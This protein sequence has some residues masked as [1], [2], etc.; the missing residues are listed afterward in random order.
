VQDLG[1]SL[2]VT[3]LV[4]LRLVPMIAFSPPFT[5]VRVPALVRVMLVLAL[6]AWLVSGHPQQTTLV[7]LD[8]LGLV[9]T[10]FAELLMG[11]ALALVLQL[12]FAA[13]MTAGRAIDLQ[14]GYAFAMIADPSSRNQ[15]PLIGMIFAYAAAAVFFATNGPADVLAIW[16][17]SIEHAPLG[18]ALSGNAPTILAAYFSTVLVMALGGAG[19][20]L[21]VLF[22]IDA[23]IALMSRTLP[24]MNVLFLGFQVKSITT[25]VLLPL[26]LAGSAALYLRIFR[27]AF[28]TMLKLV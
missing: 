19:L 23:S 5:L 1:H 26:A 24:Q 17:L 8:R 13:L 3:L 25:L 21:L 27:F 20:V 6:S 28:D 11:I 4:S 18:A 12:A 7:D 9:A 16:S 22:L 14:A 15:A 10:A 2:L